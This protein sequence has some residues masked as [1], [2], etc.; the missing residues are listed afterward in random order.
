MSEVI[1]T[2]NDIGTGI[3]SYALAVEAVAGAAT[4]Y[5]VGQ[6][7]ESR[8]LKS[9]REN[10]SAF[11]STHEDAAEQSSQDFRQSRFMRSVAKLAIAGSMVGYATGQVLRSHD[12]AITTK[13]AV[14]VVVD[15]SYGIA[16]KEDGGN[17]SVSLIDSVATSVLNN[18]NL[19]ATAYIANGDAYMKQSTSAKAVTQDSKKGVFT[20]SKSL[21][22][23]TE[24]AIDNAGSKAS[25]APGNSSNGAAVL[26][27]T[28]GS[29]LG[30]VKIVANHAKQIG[31]APIYIANA[32]PNESANAKALKQI[33]KQTGGKYWH[34][35][36]GN[37]AAIEAE[38]TESLEPRAIEVDNDGERSAW[39]LMGLLSAVSL[40]R[41]YGSRKRQLSP[42]EESINS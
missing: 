27:V 38:I 30:P 42:D 17:G 12:T 25:I 19:E 8:A 37:A 14:E 16:K 7:L 35:N 34:V 4:G 11:M 32:S 22:K 15:H 26:A 40:A 41:A 3:Q 6:I 36:S 1:N 21:I 29:T 9:I 10:R 24:K 20:G 18:E 13:P 5:A 28:D 39:F 23:A 2:I 33:A 31:N